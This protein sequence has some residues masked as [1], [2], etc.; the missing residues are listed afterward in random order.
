M[1]TILTPAEAANYVRTEESNAVLLMLLPSVD[2]FIQ[3]AT[4]RDW[5]QDTTINVLAKAAAGMLLV[6][7][8]DNPA[9]MGSSETPLAFGLTNVLSQ[10]EAQALKYRTYTFYGLSNSG[11]ISVP[12]IRVGD[13]VQK[14]IGVYGVSGDQ[15]SKFESVATETDALQQTHGGDLSDNAYA[16]VVKNPADDVGP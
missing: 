4:G 2:A 10:L 12:G 13:Q 7:W 15:A 9:Q 3:R 8:F 11:Y 5:T 16:V 1:T 6:Q 14:L